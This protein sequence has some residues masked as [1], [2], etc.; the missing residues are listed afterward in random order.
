MNYVRVILCG[1]HNHT[2]LNINLQ[3]G[4]QMSSR[5]HMTILIFNICPI[6]T[7]KSKLWALY[8]MWHNKCTSNKQLYHPA[9]RFSYGNVIV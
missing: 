4:G 8:M 9:F 3:F 7:F 6:L 1:T 2:Y 5:D